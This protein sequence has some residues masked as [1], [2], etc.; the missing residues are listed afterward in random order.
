DRP[1]H[2]SPAGASARSIAITRGARVSASASR[3]LCALQG[4]ALM[5]VSW[6]AGRIRSIIVP[7]GVVVCAELFSLTTG[8]R[9]ETLAPPHEIVLAFLSDMIDGT[10][11]TATLQTL[12][13]A[14]GGLA[15]GFSA[16][17]LAGTILGVSRLAD[18]LMFVSVE[19]IRPIP[20][21]A[22]IPIAMLVF[23]F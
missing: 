22:L 11:L 1:W 12:Y 3:T 21:I 17:V 15:I 20:S 6:A 19:I 13:G 23:G 7:F 14:L 16:G 9:S 5:S 10:L 18:R 8:Q 2:R 4:G